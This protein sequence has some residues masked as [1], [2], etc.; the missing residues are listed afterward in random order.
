MGFFQRLIRGNT[1]TQKI[2]F[3]QRLKE[4]ETQKHELIE[5]FPRLKEEETQIH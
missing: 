3:F 1:N 2:D 4:E 5:F